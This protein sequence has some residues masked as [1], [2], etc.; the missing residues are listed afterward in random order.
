MYVG[1]A[2]SVMALYICGGKRQLEKV[3]SFLP[4]YTGPADGTHL[5]RLNSKYSY[6]N[7]SSVSSPVS[8]APMP[9]ALL[10]LLLL[11][12]S[13]LVGLTGVQVAGIQLN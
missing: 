11:P 9:A 8:N 2:W 13:E 10:C 7:F 4:C 1:G 6:G 3:G 12:N 5:V